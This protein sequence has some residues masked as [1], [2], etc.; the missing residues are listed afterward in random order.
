MKHRIYAATIAL[1]IIVGSPF[2]A[3]AQGPRPSSM[4]N[5]PGMVGSTAP[6]AVPAATPFAG[7]RPSSQNN[8]PGMMNDAAPARVP[9][10]SPFNGA[11]PSS[12]H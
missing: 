4:N 12:A 2:A 6:T 5:W 11:R 7:P 9:A 3:F 1:S 8:W 10:A